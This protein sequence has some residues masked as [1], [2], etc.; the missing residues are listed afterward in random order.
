MK[1]LLALSSGGG[2]F[3]ELVRLRAA[4]AGTSVT[5][6]TVSPAYSAHVPGERLLV[7]PDATRWDR[8]RLASAV[9]RIARLVRHERPDVVVS[10][11]A[12]P[13]FFAIALGRAVGARTVFVDSFAN[14]EELSLSGRLASRVAH[15]CLTQW[16]ELARPD[17]ARFEGSVIGEVD[18]GS[19]EAPPAP[20]H[21]PLRVFVTVGAQMPFDRL[22][23]AVEAV[24]KGRALD[25]FAQ[26][27]VG[28]RACGLPGPDLLAP[29][30]FQERY[31]WADLVVAHAGTGSIL[32]ALELGKPI[33]VMA[34][35]A[36]LA[37]TRNDHQIATAARFNAR[38]GVPIFEDA[39]GLGAILDQ[40]R[41]RT[42]RVGRDAEPRLVETLRRFIAA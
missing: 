6:A 42:T 2:H 37:E 25:V 23:A 27:G 4:F 31:D 1:K 28:G 15:E 36:A 9:L 11:G 30:A 16:P 41:F 18:P 20:V 3:V 29:A 40:R 34:R 26:K 33:A 17:G 14:V 8:V 32:A 35:R 38:F 12:L 13:G 21:R 10:T 5:W 39:D 22:L 24:A 7:V 19:D